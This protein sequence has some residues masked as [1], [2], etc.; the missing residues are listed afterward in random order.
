[1]KSRMSELDMSGSVE[2][3][4]RATSPVYSTTCKWL[5]LLKFGSVW[6]LRNYRT[7]AVAAGRAKREGGWLFLIPAVF[8]F[9]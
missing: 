6:K 1:L 7:N 8:E 5:F 3:L 9:A 4:E 2:G